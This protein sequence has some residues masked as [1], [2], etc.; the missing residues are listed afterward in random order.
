MTK[1]ADILP[2]LELLSR[3]THGNNE[4][5]Q[6]AS[7]NLV[8]D[9]CVGFLQ[10]SDPQLKSKALRVLSGVSSNNGTLQEGNKMPFFSNLRKLTSFCF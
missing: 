3:L 5:Q 6:E 10:S 1:T 8:L 2:A 4:S 9:I 7:I